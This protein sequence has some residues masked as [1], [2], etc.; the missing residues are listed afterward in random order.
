[1]KYTIKNIADMLDNANPERV[2]VLNLQPNHIENVAHW[3]KYIRITLTN[4]I[5]IKI[6]NF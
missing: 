5:K 1:M 3:G 2:E 6:K 4:G